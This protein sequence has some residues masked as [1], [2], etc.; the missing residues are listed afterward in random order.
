MTWQAGFSA[1][2][3]GGITFLA[4]ALAITGLGHAI[5]WLRGLG[6]LMDDGDGQDGVPAATR[7]L[8]ALGDLVINPEAER[9]ASHRAL[10][11]PDPAGDCRFCRP[12]F[13]VT[14]ACTCP[15]ACG[16]S[17]CGALQWAAAASTEE[18][19]RW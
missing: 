1:I 13:E 18:W 16:D 14:A 17:Q 12:P 7:P 8:T 2:A 11:G 15:G 5:R 10:T 6:R 4:G 9:H 19:E 3:W